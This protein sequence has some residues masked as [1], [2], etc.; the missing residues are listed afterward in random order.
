MSLAGNNTFTGHGSVNATDTESGSIYIGGEQNFDLGATFNGTKIGLD[1]KVTLGSGD[2]IFNGNTV[3]LGTNANINATA[4]NL[5]FTS[6][7]GDLGLA[8]G[9]QGTA[10]PRHSLW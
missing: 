9:S 7:S 1:G 3:T 5:D 8:S 2:G 10:S 4:G 6:S